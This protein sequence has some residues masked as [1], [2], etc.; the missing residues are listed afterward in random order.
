MKKWHRCVGLIT[1]LSASWMQA[2][3][4]CSLQK[5]NAHSSL[6]SKKK[7]FNASTVVLRNDMVLPVRLMVSSQ[8]DVEHEVILLQH[9]EISIRQNERIIRWGM[10]G[11]FVNFYE[12]QLNIEEL[13]QLP[14]IFLWPDNIY[15]I[16]ITVAV[17]EAIYNLRS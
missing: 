17:I 16:S 8:H 14:G 6:F 5:I 13:H 12:H 1:L 7:S 2:D 4:P 9:D 15:F 3:V 10:A 11:G